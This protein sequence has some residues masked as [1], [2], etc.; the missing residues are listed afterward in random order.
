MRIDTL[1]KLDR[2][3][4]R[5][6]GEKRDTVTVARKEM[7]I[8]IKNRGFFT[9]VLPFSDENYAKMIERVKCVCESLKIDYSKIMNV[10]NKIIRD[11]SSNFESLKKINLA[12]RLIEMHPDPNAYAHL[13]DGEKRY[14]DV[15]LHRSDKLG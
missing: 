6:C 9:K 5:Y 4:K 7:V 13:G 11:E 12:K 3:I 15:L 1:K 14:S 10:L 8:W 2:F